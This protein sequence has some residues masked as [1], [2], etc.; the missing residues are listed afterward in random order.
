MRAAVTE[1]LAGHRY[2]ARYSDTFRGRLP[3]G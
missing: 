3:A 2:T 1:K